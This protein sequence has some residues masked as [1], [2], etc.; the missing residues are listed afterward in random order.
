MNDRLQ[1]VRNKMQ[2]L[3]LQGMIIANPVNIKYLTK[4][5]AE[6]ILLLTRKENIFITD[7]R[8][9][10]YVSSII[11]PFDDIVVDNLKNISADEYENFFLF[12][13]NVGFEEK[14]L[15][16]ATYKDYIRKY[17]IN[18]FVEAEEIISSLRTIKDETEIAS[19][20]RACEITDKCFSMILEYIKPG[21]TEKQI[22]RKIHEF[23]LD[24][25]EGESFE[26]I[27]ASGENS[28]KPHA[29]VTDRIIKEKD[30]I[31]IDMGC[32]I[33][34]YCSDMTR[35]IFIGEPT[36]EQKKVYNLVL[37]NQKR[38]LNEI[39]DGVCI[40]TI[41]KGVESNFNI[42]NH[43]LIHS[44]GHGVGLDIHETPAISLKN[45]GFL[46]ENMIITDEPRNLSPWRI[47]YKNRRYCISHEERGNILD[48]IGKRMYN[49]LSIFYKLKGDLIW[50]Q[51]IQQEILEMEQHLK[52][53][54]MYI[55]L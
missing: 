14:Y 31:T 37:E 4:I 43:T 55:E 47:W 15:S 28:S 33:N 12:C 38:A 22:S 2:G 26:T 30:I 39:R 36:E 46:K 40:K 53:K 24:N 19:I 6:G 42:E 23:F 11:T 18:N 3:N 10:E 35:T 16:Y 50:Q 21:L 29:I 9:M 32:K 52:W 1:A 49:N 20:K 27:V 17:K 48:R 34:G 5:D 51:Y 8:Y 54:E 41:V 44:L 13:E 25:S 45:D 7:G